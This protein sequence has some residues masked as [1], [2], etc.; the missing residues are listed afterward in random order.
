MPR[1]TPA[2]TLSPAE[3]WDWSQDN[4]NGKFVRM[5]RGSD[6]P[7]AEPGPFS[8]EDVA[9]KFV[10][11]MIDNAEYWAT[12]KLE[13]E[14]DN[15]AYR[16]EGVAFSTLSMID[17]SNIDFPGVRL[18]IQGID[19]DDADE[20]KWHVDRGLNYYE[21]RNQAFNDGIELHDMFYPQLEQ[22]EAAKKKAVDQR[23]EEIPVNQKP[24][25]GTPVEVM[26]ATE[27]MYQLAH[28]TFGVVET[29][30]STLPESLTRREVCHAIAESV[31]G[32]V[33][34]GIFD[35]P[36]FHLTP[37]LDETTDIVNM[38]DRSDGIEV[39]EWDYGIALQPQGA[40]NEPS[41]TDHYAN[42]YDKTRGRM[43]LAA[44]QL[45]GGG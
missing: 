13:P 31:L 5:L 18:A 17:G 38:L 44:Y 29:M 34:D 43:T 12:V 20:I 21:G 1:D 42:I 4:M 37:V 8:E 10:N 7:I 23:Y 9:E 25:E 27:Q 35:S 41:L 26:S 2:K 3:A 16:C 11:K 14:N 39:K 30:A 36:P 22:R 19:P 6:E 15:A 45:F 33:Q 40:E 28:T 32:I 24:V